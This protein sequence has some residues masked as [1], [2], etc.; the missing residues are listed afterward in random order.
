LRI[1]SDEELK[2]EVAKILSEHSCMKIK[3]LKRILNE[4]GFKTNQW[5]LAYLMR[6]DGRFT[7]DHKNW[8][9]KND[10]S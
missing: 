1:H 6:T 10:S 8:R 7:L 9:L 2:D 5:Q 4:R 3:T